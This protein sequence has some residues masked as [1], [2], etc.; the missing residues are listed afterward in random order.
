MTGIPNVYNRETINFKNY[1]KNPMEFIERVEENIAR[2]CETRWTTIRSM[3]DEQIKDMYNNWWPATRHEVQNYAN[4]KTLFKT[5]YWSESTQNLSLIHIQ[6]C[7]RDR[8]NPLPLFYGYTYCLLLILLSL[9]H[10]QMCIRDSVFIIIKFCISD[11]F[12]PIQSIIESGS[13]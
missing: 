3:L 4:F 1:K 10:I 6:M 9:I 7:I 2:T 11:L 5:K 13:E 8:P 12:H